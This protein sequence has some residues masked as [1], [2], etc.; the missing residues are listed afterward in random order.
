[1]NQND[2]IIEIND[3]FGEWFEVAGDRSSDLMIN[4]LSN[5]LIKEREHNE[6]LTRR[7]QYVCVTSTN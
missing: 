4:I 1:M 3:K 5:L 7:L 6:Y 2:L